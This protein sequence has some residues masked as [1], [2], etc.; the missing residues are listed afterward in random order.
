MKKLKI[1]KYSSKNF[2]TG[3]YNDVF[4]WLKKVETN[5]IPVNEWK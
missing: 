1:S 5:S 4:Y 3:Q 2:I